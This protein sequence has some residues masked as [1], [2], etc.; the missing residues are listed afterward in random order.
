MSFTERSRRLNVLVVMPPCLPTPPE[1][2]GGIE[3]VAAALLPKLEQQGVRITVTTPI[4]STVNVTERLEITEPLY[5]ILSHPYNEVVPPIEEYIAKV[6]ELIWSRSFDVVHD[7]SGMLSILNTVAAP[8]MAGAYP[9]VIHT[10]HGPIAPYVGTYERLAGYPGLTYTGISQAQMKDAPPMMKART[11]TIYNG[12][13]VD[14]YPAGQGGDRVL[15][16]GRICQDKGQDRLVDFAAETG[17]SLDI[18]GTVAEVSSLADIEAE[19]AKGFQNPIV[20][21]ADFQTYL[22]FKDKIDGE[23][24]KFYGNV[25]GSLKHSLL[26]GASVL[27]VPNRWD[28]PF[29]MVAI[30]AMASGTPVVAMASGAMPE[31]II[32]GVTGYLAETWEEF[33]DYLK[34]EMIAKLDRAACRQ[35]VIDNF[36]IDSIAREYEG[37]YRAAVAAII[38]SKEVVPAFIRPQLAMMYERL[39]QKGQKSSR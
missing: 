31:L 1:G 23:N 37:L 18:A 19:I 16:L 3:A 26:G 36:S 5:P 10:I 38:P 17:M 32:H 33:C 28:E 15:V 8:L 2:Y 27:A 6:M 14:D 9:P 30:E 24:I 7:F 4:G 22:L 21:K 12:L 20:R 39:P 35:H 25:G 11:K 34:P 13:N 29:G